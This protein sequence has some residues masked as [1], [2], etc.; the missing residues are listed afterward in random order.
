MPVL[1]NFAIVRAI[2]DGLLKID[3]ESPEPDQPGTLY[4]TTA[5]DLR[6]S[7]SILVPK[8]N[9]GL[10]FDLR[11]GS[12]IPALEAV[13][14]RETIPS[15]G[16]TLQPNQFIL[17][18]TIE[19]VELPLVE[20]GLAARIEGR[21]SYARTGLLVHFTAPTI[22]AGFAGRL[23]LEMINLG[24]LS[25]VLFPEVRICQLIFERVE[26]VPG[27]NDSQFQGQAAPSGVR[28]P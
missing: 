14:N 27:R 1:S 24:P 21:S 11:T 2:R 17:G 13:C 16:W 10:A 6:L 19:R 28:N 25:L 8:P 18:T 9:L 7:P 20:N 4:D 15:T 12:V 26:G 22:H 5:I 3:P 23:T